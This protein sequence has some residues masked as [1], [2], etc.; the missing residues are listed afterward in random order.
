MEM[1]YLLVVGIVLYAV[2]DWIVK[3][4][5][6]AAGRR[7]EQRTLIFFAI[8]LVLALSSFALIQRLA[9]TE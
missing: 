6:A 7:L 5:E 2:S 9:G 3:R 1:L 4:I 8:L